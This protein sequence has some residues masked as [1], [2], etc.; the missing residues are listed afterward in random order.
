MRIG[1]VILIV[2]VFTIGLT[3]A[4]LAA[5]TDTIVV[6]ATPVFLSI[7]NSPDTWTINGCL[8][9]AVGKEGDGKIRKNVTYYSNPLGDLDVPSATVVDEECQ[10]TVTNTSNVITDITVNFPNFAGGDAMTNS[11]TGSNGATSFGAYSWY[12]GMTYAN[13]VIAKAS[14]SDILIGSLAATTNKKF[15]IEVKTQTGAF[16]SVTPMTSSVVIAVTEH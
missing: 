11:N 2:L 15:G 12:S 14:G 9:P 7:D 5:E 3:G 10:F 6:T 8:I 13:K 4:V 1:L 16:T